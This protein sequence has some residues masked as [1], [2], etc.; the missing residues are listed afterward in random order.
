M[1]KQTNKQVTTM[2]DLLRRQAQQWPEQTAYTFLTDGEEQATDLT[3]GGLDQ[4]ARAIAAWLQGQGIVGQR[5]LLLY[6]QGLAYLE[7]FFGCLYSGNVAVPSYPPRL[8][9]ADPRLG[10]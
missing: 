5:V 2:I 1:T 10:G 3:Y 8:N 4:R 6:P 9:R 7:A